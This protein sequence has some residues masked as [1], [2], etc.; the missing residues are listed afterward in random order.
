MT[1]LRNYLS[2][3]VD[4]WL[5][6]LGLAYIATVFFAP[7]GIL[8]LVP[9]RWR[10]ASAVGQEPA[11]ADPSLEVRAFAL[12]RWVDASGPRPIDRDAGRSRR[13]GNAPSRRHWQDLRTGSC[14]ARSL[15]DGVR[16]HP[17]SDPW[18]ERGRQDD[19]VQLDHRR[20]QAVP[21]DPSIC[22]V[23]TSRACLL[24][25]GRGWDSVA[26]SRSPIS[27]PHSRS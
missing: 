5:I 26:R 25:C 7:R 13:S 11:V 1:G 6:V 18:T 24:T 8:G 22:S 15:A 20:L 17:A 12:S 16:W 19:V 9:R 10:A 2:V 23:G 4:N 21:V 14:G 27:S 3:Y